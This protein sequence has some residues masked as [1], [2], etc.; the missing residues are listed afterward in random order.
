MSKNSFFAFLIVLALINAIYADDGDTIEL[1]HKAGYVYVK[2]QDIQKGCARFYI[3]DP[4][5]EVQGTKYWQVCSAPSRDKEA[6]VAIGSGVFAKIKDKYGMES[7]NSI[8]F[9]STGPQCWVSIYAEKQGQGHNYDITPLRDVDLSMVTN[10]DNPDQT[11]FNDNIISGTIRST[12]GTD[13]NPDTLLTPIGATPIAVW[14]RFVGAPRIEPDSGCGYFYQADPTLGDTNGFVVCVSAEQHL[15][16]V[17]LKDMVDRGLVLKGKQPYVNGTISKFQDPDSGEPQD[18]NGEALPFLMAEPW[19]GDEEHALEAAKKYHRMA[20]RKLRGLQEQESNNTFFSGLATFWEEV[21]DV[22]DSIA[23]ATIEIFTG[24]PN[25]TEVPTLAP[26]QAPIVDAAPVAPKPTFAPV[27]H[28][29]WDRT[30]VRYVE[31]GPDVD[32]AIWTNDNFSGIQELIK[33]GSAKLIEG[34]VTNS[35]FLVSHKYK[36]SHVKTPEF[37]EERGVANVAKFVRKANK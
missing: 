33:S 19:E 36:E 5:T 11:T 28:S 24:P 12:D 17:S 34:K 27:K 18:E 3:S 8:S 2:P 14:Y 23:E 13:E 25:S 37:N 26:F 7:A 22:A 16:H 10:K 9:I 32:V 21:V 1:P 15:A 4:I 20:Q 35:F 31:A 6:K 29:K 30:N